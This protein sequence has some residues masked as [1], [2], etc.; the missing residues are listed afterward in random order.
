MGATGQRSQLD[1]K[2]RKTNNEDISQGET[3]SDQVDSALLQTNSPAN[4]KIIEE[5]YLSYQSEERKRAEAIAAL[6][7]LNQK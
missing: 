6:K 7:K 4:R 1:T 3:P 2:M 5:A